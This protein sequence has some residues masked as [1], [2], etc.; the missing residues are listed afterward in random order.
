MDSGL[1]QRWVTAAG[2]ERAEEAVACLVAG[3]PL[4]GLGLGEVDG[5]ADLRGLPAPV[6]RR[7]RRFEA[8]GWF[9]EE[10]GELV[11]LRGVRLEGLDLR[12]A[13]L[14]SFRFFGSVMADCR[15]DGANCQDWRMWD[16]HVADSSFSGVSLKDAAVGPWHDGKGNS[17]R[18]ISFAKADF[19]VASPTGTVFAEC[20]F[21]G[22]RLSR[23]R[24]QQCAITGCRFSGKI[25]GVV[26]DGRRLDGK[27]VPGPL[28]ADFAGAVFEDVMF[29]G[30]DLSG[31]VLP[32]D[33]DL[34]LIRQ[35]RCV[36]ERALTLLGE[37]DSL[38][39]RMLRGEFTNRLK[40]IRDTAVPER[41]VF[42]RRDYVASGGQEL[43]DLAERVLTMAEAQCQA[44]GPA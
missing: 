2:R 29:L 27:P 26:F 18:R 19:R 15:L 7:L 25:A 5:R 17:W 32:D 43:A 34:R 30:Y 24:F 1:G 39:T 20:D 35:D 9:A 37:G 16:T 3:R 44:E 4:A 38:P 40:S 41:E 14:Q 28:E 6:P 33:R 23:V 8:A 10:L 21:S 36:M 13:Q 22:A 11:T 12:G 31:V 42:N